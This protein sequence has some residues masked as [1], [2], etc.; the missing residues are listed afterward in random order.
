MRR[1]EQGRGRVLLVGRLPLPLHNLLAGDQCR[2][3]VQQLFQRSLMAGRT[4]ALL[5]QHVQDELPLVFQLGGDLVQLTKSQLQG[6]PS[7]VGIV[8][9]GS[10]CS[11]GGRHDL[12]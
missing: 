3:H 11:R 8:R 9:R 6:V 4:G 12:N 1:G 2:C 10:G 5:A 7:E